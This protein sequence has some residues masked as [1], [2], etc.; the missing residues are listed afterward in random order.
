MLPGAVTHAGHCPRWL[1]QP[2]LAERL[3]LMTAPRATVLRS[4]GD[5]VQ[6]VDD[7]E[8]IEAVDLL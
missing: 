2:S 5:R 6:C 1:P 7:P 8:A 3:L 4:L